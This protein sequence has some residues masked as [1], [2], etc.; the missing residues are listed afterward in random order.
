MLLKRYFDFRG[1][2]SRTEYWLFVIGALAAFIV[3]RLIDDA[4]GY[5][6]AIS[7]SRGYVRSTVG[8]FVAIVTFGLLIP[9]FTVAVRR[10]HDTDRRGWWILAPLLPPVVILPLMQLFEWM[11]FVLIGLAFAVG[12]L[13]NLVFLLLPGT[14]GPNRFGSAPGPAGLRA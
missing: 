11:G 1:R 6:S 8:P 10:L 9:A 12:T 4:T 2:A 5:G 7:D 13:I 3:A 14:P